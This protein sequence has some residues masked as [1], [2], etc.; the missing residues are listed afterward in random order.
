M[1]G[2]AIATETKTRACAAEGA[3]KRALAIM[4]A[5]IEFLRNL[6]NFIVYLPAY[7]SFALTFEDFAE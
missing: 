4:A 1:G 3:I 6:V 7:P 2:G 5:P